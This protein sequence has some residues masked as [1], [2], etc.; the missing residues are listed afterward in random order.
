M[1]AESPA[2]TGV[3]LEFMF[4]LGQAY[5]AC[6][7]QTAQVELIL[8]RVAAANGAR[9]TRVLAFPTAVFIT[10]HDGE[11]ER[12]TLAEGP[13]E[14]LR[15]DQMADVYAIGAAAQR[16]ELA[17]AEGLERLTAAMRQQA[18]FGRTG[19]LL[20]HAILTLGLAMILTPSLASLAAAGALG[21]I[22]GLVKE[23]NGNKPILAMPLPVVAAALVSGL[24]FLAAGRGFPA[25]PLQLMV[26]PLVTFL[27]G[28]M[29]TLAMVEL[30][31]GDMMS[32]SSR[33]IT[34]FVQLAL[35]AFGLACGA[36]LVGWDAEDLLASAAQQPAVWWAPWVGVLVFGLGV[37]LH[38]S[39]PR[40]SLHWMLGVLVVVFATQ[41]LAARL[42]PDEISG[43]FGMLVATPLGYLVQL[44]FKVPPAMVTSLP[45]FW[46]VVPGSLGLLSVTQMLGDRAAG[47]D[48]LVTVVV[49]LISVALGTLVGAGLYK[50]LTETFG[51]WQLQIG[52]ALRRG[53]GR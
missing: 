12:V 31:Y 8:R 20:G 36:E 35:L 42:G 24:V 11:E 52:R 15:L 38:F 43:F 46:I 23:L 14:A 1:R 30:A 21:G 53:A 37:Y 6:G 27:P 49:I 25:D 29:L 28:A 41:R 44:R 47:I 32:G 51:W 3:L 50:W 34:G 40:N 48:G 22:V 4:R 17:P 2:D 33:L 16:G 9:R 5:I 26:P 13:L 39:A 10:L 19:S 45:S 7:E 18:R